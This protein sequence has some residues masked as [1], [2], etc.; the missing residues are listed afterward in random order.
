MFQILIN[1]GPCIFAVLNP[2]DMFRLFS[3]R[4]TLLIVQSYLS[5][6]NTK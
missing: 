3:Q 6:V 5:E 4:K 1:K 2:G